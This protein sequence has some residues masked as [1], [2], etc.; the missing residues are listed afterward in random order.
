MT[1]Y[2]HLSDIK[3]KGKISADEIGIGTD[4][5]EQSLEDKIA[6]TV[7]KS[8][9]SAD[10][11]TSAT[12]ATNATNAVSAD[13]ASKDAAGNT[14]TETYVTKT[15]K[16]A[17]K[18][19]SGD[20]TLAP[21]DVGALAA[22]GTAVKATADGSG[23]NIA[24]TYATQNYVNTELAKK[25][26]SLTIDNVLSADSE[27]PVQN[28]VI[29]TA[30]DAKVDTA[31]YNAGI[32]SK[33]DKSAF[34]THETNYQAHITEYNA[35]VNAFDEH[36]TEM[37]T[38]LSTNYYNRTQ[39][40]AA[41]A[42]AVA[43]SFKPK[44]S[45]AS[46]SA[47]PATGNTIGDVRNVQDTGMNYVWVDVD[48]TA[49]WDALSGIVD[50][51]PY[52]KSTDAATTYLAK[53]DAAASAAKLTT[54]N[55]GAATRPV[56]FANG[57]PVQCD[58]SLAVDITGNAATATTAGACSGNAATAT[59][60]GSCTGNAATATKATQDGNGNNI[61]TTYQKK[62]MTGTFTVA[63]SS[64]TASSVAT[65]YGYQA[66]I[67]AS[68]VTE[69]DYPVVSFDPTFATG[70]QL[71]PFADTVADGIRIYSKVNTIAPTGSWMAVDMA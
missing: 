26:D 11:A 19:L 17:G 37:E 15:T 28:K 27:N 12:N 69:A 31:T 13:K 59:T 23:N 70:G 56:Y 53:T 25:Q 60:A 1:E 42:A 18:E 46:A 8:A 24:G 10:N 4:G 35:H 33:A 30:I 51:T 9:L 2:T 61:V 20:I 65:G 34:D 36:I 5:N 66:T 50:L 52:L 43:S 22:D 38:N 41:I 14:I 58:E 68:G 47:L 45:V 48:G 21:S 7:V 3:V 16:V 71:A 64:W 63:A 6:N 32:A 40:D 55:M 44:A 39:A 57:V 67:S 29:K 54:N 49:K 62:V